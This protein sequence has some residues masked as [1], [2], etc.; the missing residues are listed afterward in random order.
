MDYVNEI[1]AV[2]EPPAPW[3]LER[4]ADDFAGLVR[5]L[6]EQSQGVGLKEGW[7]ASS[8]FWLASSDER[9]L[10]VVNLRHKLTD[11][12]RD[13]GGHIGY[14]VRPS[15]RNKGYA[16]RMLRL[17]LDKA[18]ALGIHR[19]LVTCDAD[20]IASQRVIL[21]NGGVLDSESYSEQAGRVTQRYW[22]DLPEGAGN[23]V[24]H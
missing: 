4:H 8:T 7:V 21:K 23:H 13:F 11:K 24:R 10:G 18:R 16:T 15:E 12:L 1:R 19:V 17:T 5:W 22:I 2:G 20:N 6:N 9:I 14:G 3:V